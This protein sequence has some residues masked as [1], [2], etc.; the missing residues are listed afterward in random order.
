LSASL[1]LELMRASALL[2]NDPAAAARR[3]IAILAKSPGRDEAI[4]LLAAARRRLGGTQAAADLQGAADSMESL[5]RRQPTSPLLQLELGLAYAACGRTRE[6]IAALER[7]VGL[8]GGL[9]EGWRELAVQQLLAGN[10]AAADVAYLNYRRLAADPADL[11]D[12]YAAF[13]E[14]RLDAADAAAQSRLPASTNPVAVLTLLAAIAAKR[15][16]DLAEED[17]LNRILS[18]APCDNAARRQLAQLLLRLERSKEALPMIERLLAADSRNGAI[19]VLKSE[20]LQLAERHGEGLDVVTE[21]LAQEPQNPDYWLIAGNQ[22]RFM[23]KTADAIRSYQRAIDL[24]PAYGLAYWALSNLKTYHFNAAEIATMRRELDAAPASSVDATHL[25]FALGQA[26]E[27]GLEFAGSF[28]HYRRGNELSRAAFSYDAGAATA[29]V[30]RFKSTYTRRFFDERGDWGNAAPD[31]IF[32]VGLPRSGSTLLEQILAS[33]SEVEAT[34]EL[35]YIPRIAREL[36]GPPEIAARYPENLPAAGRS[37][38]EALAGRYLASAQAHRLQGKPRFI[39]KMHG[40][41]AS[42]GLIHLMFPRA[43]IIDVRRHPMGC[44]FACYKQLFA[45][46]MNFAYD[47]KELGLYY[48]DYVD[49]ME[50]VDGVLPQRV[51]RLH[52]ER[53][54]A[55]TAN[56]IQRVLDYCNLPFEAACLRFHE[57]QRVAQTISSEQVR[58]PMYAEGVDQWRHYEAWLGPLREPLGHL[59]ESYPRF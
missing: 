59:I 50:H 19:L 23:G 21:L 38:L 17:A 30:K 46:G 16:D 44:A 51:Y 58:R 43:A 55:D 42:L 36:A 53:L 1:E 25:E 18:L 15:G 34:R 8:D 31:P 48:R 52:Y 56:E 47:L 45:P 41:F 49:L 27:A 37:H 35:A 4:L 29:F 33:H 9:T 6:A 26:L 13:D 24:R 12:A 3:A 54:V 40:N 39:D 2:E 7:S 32:I 22:Q 5:A 20:A 10:T 11:A 14:S 57:N 28:E